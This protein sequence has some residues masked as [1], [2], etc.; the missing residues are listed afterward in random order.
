M[1]DVVDRSRLYPHLQGLFHC[2]DS[3]LPRAICTARGSR[4]PPDFQLSKGFPRVALARRSRSLPSW[5]SSS[6]QAK[7]FASIALQGFTKQPGWLVS[8]ETAA[9]SELPAPHS[10]PSRSIPPSA[11]AYRFA[12]SRSWCRHHSP[13]Q[14][15]RRKLSTGAKKV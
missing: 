11:L 1:L 14:L 12:L 4:S 3:T 13:G 7:A 15:R 6:A 9:L 2:R 10:L 5:A 8:E